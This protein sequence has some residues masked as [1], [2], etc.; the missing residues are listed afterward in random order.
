MNVLLEL[1]HGFVYNFL[2]DLATRSTF[3]TVGDFVVAATVCVGFYIVRK[4]MKTVNGKC[5]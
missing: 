3:L 1:A 4:Q 2:A 5:F